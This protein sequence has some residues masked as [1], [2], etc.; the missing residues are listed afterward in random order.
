MSLLLIT[1]HRID[2]R[3]VVLAGRDDARAVLA[4]R[5]LPHRIVM[6]RVSGELVSSVGVRTRTVSS[7]LVVTMR[8]A[9]GLN[10]D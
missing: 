9:P 8:A 7:A 5:G 2:P 1:E 4:E 6:S 10:D 3:S